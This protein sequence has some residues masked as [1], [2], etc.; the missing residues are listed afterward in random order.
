MAVPRT[1]LARWLG[2]QRYE[3]VLEL[4]R[5]LFQARQAG[6]IGDVALL[7]E[8]DPVI[9]MGRGTKPSHLLASP[10]F[11]AQIGVDLV[12]VDR[13]G[14]I[15]LHAPGQLVCYP[16]IDLGP[17]RRDVRRYVRALSESMRRIV[18]DFDL[19]AGTVDGMVGLWID[20]ESPAHWP[21]QA[22]AQRMAKIG[23]IGVRISRWVTMHGFALNLATDLR[24]F[25][26]IVPCGI[27]AHP[28]TSV[29]TLTGQTVTV[30]ETA[31]RAFRHLCDVLEAD[32]GE[33]LDE[34]SQR[35]EG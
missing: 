24:Q 3:P 31:P 7:V 34:S 8:H 35:L 6:Q 10:R 20:E 26:L 29:Q 9:T 30:G 5:N 11:L 2:R 15:T 28:V 33:Y 23:A 25:G 22:D 13:G 4:Q 14:D 19:D 21:G 32:P 1:L 12:E 27:S 18:N 16:I 17:D